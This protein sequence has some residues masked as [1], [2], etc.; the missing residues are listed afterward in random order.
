[1]SPQESDCKVHMNLD[2]ENLD[3][4]LTF[5]CAFVRTQIAQ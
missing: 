2:M 5:L 3:F 4:S 1:M